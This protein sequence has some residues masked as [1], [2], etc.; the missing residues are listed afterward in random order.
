[1]RYVTTAALAAW[2]LA[3]AAAQG[4]QLRSMVVPPEA[5]VAVPPRGLP[6]MASPSAARP[7]PAPSP[8][9][10]L[11]PPDRAGTDLAGAAP[12]LLPL[13]AALLLGAGNPGSSGSASAPATTR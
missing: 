7:V 5:G 9:E 3:T 4:Q 2:V 6:L 10:D 11:P 12:F 13:I 8:P 1:M